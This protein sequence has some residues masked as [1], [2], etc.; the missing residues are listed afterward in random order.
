MKN[1]R[2]NLPFLLLAIVVF[3]LL[4]YMNT[5][6]SSEISYGDFR[7]ALTSNPSQ[8]K[9]AQ[10]DSN[11]DKILLIKKDQSRETVR[12][13]H[14][15][16]NRGLADEMIKAGIKTK[17]TVSRGDQV[18]GWLIALGPL[19]IML[20]LI[21][22]F[23]RGMQVGGGQA[24]NFIRSKA[25]LFGEHKVRVTFADVAGVDEAK[26]ELEEVVDFLKDGD[27]FR[28]LGATIP[29]GILLVGPPGTGKT[30][31]AKA[32]AGEAGVPFFSIS[33]SDFVEMFVGV[34]ASRVRDLFEQA[35]KQSPCIVFV[36]E[37]DAV[38]RQRG[39][40]MG[41]HD[42][43]EQT[44][45]QLLVEMD[46]FETTA[47][48]V[49]ILAA[50]NRPDILDSALTRPGRFDRQVI[51][52]YPDV[53]GREDILRVHV[54]A[55]PLAPEVDLRVLAKRTP[56]FTG[57]QLANL[58]NESALI[59][60]GKSKKQVENEDLDE[61]IDKVIAGPKRA[62][63]APFKEREITAYHE[64][65]HALV[66]LCDEN[67]MP[68]HKL[69]II[70][71]G[72]SLGATWYLPEDDSQHI[73]RKMLLSQI[74]TALGGR[75]AEEIIFGDITTGASNDLQVCT[76]IARR[77]VT[78]FGMSDLGP[79]A[80]G[81]ERENFLGEFGHARDYSEE[82]ARQIDD[83]VQRMIKDSYQEVKDLLNRKR[84]VM[85]A[86]VLELLDKET[87]DRDEVKAIIK[88]VEETTFNFAEA[89]DRIQ[90]LKIKLEEKNNQSS[91]D[92][93]S[94]PISAVACLR[95]E[96]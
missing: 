18:I 89:R 74:K 94:V 14:D 23:M 71:R 6:Q 64:T 76:K 85:E 38:G 32:I 73:T 44:L 78:Q 51:I 50:T 20:P 48:N 15:Q 60:A 49:I 45:N 61:A 56:G 34:G 69:T 92:A 17:V 46:G 8:Y 31:L 28:A 5:S 68:L 79:I 59:A 63:W 96:A 24:F 55:K 53:R 25:K 82:I 47:N 93:T 77:M 86:I 95:P 40:G 72:V 12:L 41:G 42:E 67:A 11:N 19:L 1:I 7:T 2:S 66:A 80:F 65:G 37:I 43:R 29:K 39:V 27:R 91:R 22:L 84:E 33:G 75:A 54:K 30:L 70:P 57:A 4:V 26:K 35:R 3:I 88:Q 87:L 62:L 58:L 21:F 81:K 90:T 83:R 52:N 10:F 16:N 13:P 9:E 36:D